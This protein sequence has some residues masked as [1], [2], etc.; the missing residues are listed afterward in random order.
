MCGRAISGVSPPWSLS[1]AE[2]CSPEDRLCR[3]LMQFQANAT[4]PN[5]QKWQENVL[6]A[7]W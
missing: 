7:P 5:P 3:S 4:A 2:G 6:L 1:M